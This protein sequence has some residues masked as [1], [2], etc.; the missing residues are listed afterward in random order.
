MVVY[1]NMG[2]IETWVSQYPNS[3][4]RK[5]Y[6]S[7]VYTFL[8]QVY[9]F[10]KEK[11]VTQKGV[12]KYEDLA[13]RYFS[14]NRDYTQDLLQ[15]AASFEGK[16][17][18]T[19]KS[20][21]SSVKEFLVSNDVEINEKDARKI[22]KRSPK[23]GA[24]TVE[25]DLDIET[26]RSILNHSDTK[27]RALIV[28]L[29]SSGM[30]IGEALALRLS[31]IDITGE[32]GTINIRG[33][34]TKNGNQRYTFCSHE[35]CDFIHEWLKIRDSYLKET[36]NKG[37]GLNIVKS[38]ES[39]LV[40]PFSDTTAGQG[41]ITAVKAAGLYS[42]DPFTNRLQ[43]HFHMLRKFFSSQLRIVV[44]VDIV[45]GLIGHSGYLSDAYRRYTKNQVREF[46]LKGE[47][48]VTILTPKDYREMK[49]EMNERFQ[50]HSEILESIVKENL[51]LKEKISKIEKE[52]EQ[53][54]ATSELL[55]VL[56]SGNKEAQEIFEKILKASA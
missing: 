56:M 4:T 42:L 14:E 29:A 7:S 26:L 5:A 45:E 44:P 9:N 12:L 3:H 53:I 2:R 16:P 47:Q 54:R 46:Y 51:S 24:A 21:I 34:N 31:D 18:K 8:A 15:F 37:R 52:Q 20:Y 39:D 19:A 22:R 6:A 35:A 10:E 55:Q 49:T 30:R 23:G 32:I 27:M 1:L 13:D 11:K 43:I 41:W 50:S 36:E 28:L 25:R 17:P 38:V 33:E 40:F 48:Y